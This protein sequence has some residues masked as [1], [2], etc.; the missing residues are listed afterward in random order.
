MKIYIYSDLNGD[1]LR[2]LRSAFD[3]HDLMARSEGRGRD[4][5]AA[6]E[7]LMGNPPAEWFQQPSELRFWQLDSAGFDQYR[8]LNLKIPVANMGDYFSAKCAETMVGGILSFYRNIHELVRLQQERKWVGRPLRYSMD[9]LTGKNVIILGAGTISQSIVKLLRG[10]DCL[11]RLAA[12][13]N[14]QAQILSREDLIRALPDASLVIN[15]LPGNVQHYADAT[16]FNAMA[17]GSLYATVGRG[18]TTDEGALINALQMG[19]IG[20]AVLDVTEFE[21]L[22]AESPLWKMKNVILT[23]HTGGG[24]KLEDEGKVE[25]FIKNANRFLKGEPIHNPVNLVSGY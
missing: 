4:D 6:S 21:P 19:K 17:T 15:T 11:I 24:Y 1:L 5:F 25:Q 8:K 10:F 12:R 23:Q 14:P 16:F 3:A 18:N 20:G 13:N 22:P 7:I 2:R 9:L